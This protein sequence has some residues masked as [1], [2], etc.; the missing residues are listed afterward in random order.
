MEGL[1]GESAPTGVDGR[2]NRVSMHFPEHAKLQLQAEPFTGKEGQDPIKWFAIVESEFDSW[3]MNLP[4]EVRI[5]KVVVRFR[6][7]AQTFWLSRSRQ[8]P[9]V[10]SF[11]EFKNELVS[12]F[13][14]ENQYR[15]Q[16][17]KF[18]NA[19]QNGTVSSYNTYVQNLLLDLPEADGKFVLE[20]YMNGLRNDVYN[21]V[22]QADPKSV[23][24][25]MRYAL[26]Y[27]SEARMPYSKTNHSKGGNGRS[28]FTQTRG[29]A[30]Q[31][32]A[33]MELGNIRVGLQN[34]RRN[35]PTSSPRSVRSGAGTPRRS[36]NKCYACGK[37]GHFAR[38]CRTAQHLQCSTC[39]KNGHIADTCRS[40][41]NAAT[42]QV[43]HAMYVQ[44]EDSVRNHFQ[45][46]S[47][48]NVSKN[49]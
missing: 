47:R 23:Y 18:L 24:D 34:S 6:D 30:M 7:A 8:G 31:G 37:N 49:G 14:P 45:V 43:S 13:S 16:L 48:N 1:Q 4:D 15:R 27:E 28:S 42:A 3:G 25:A 21:F 35:S 11:Q 46:V 22:M 29:V 12:R 33:P 39:G 19:K 9:A 2:Q 10:G 17:R 41:L 38:D 26:S 20:V 5:K 36:G 40:Q 44:D 32:P